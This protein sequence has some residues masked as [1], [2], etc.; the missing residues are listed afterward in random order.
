VREGEREREND[1]ERQGGALERELEIQGMRGREGE[2]AAHE[3]GV[4]DAG[5]RDAGRRSVG[6]AALAVA[7][8]P[9]PVRAM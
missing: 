9:H 1:N 4:E 8:Q 6:D 3:R 7:P 2:S 5:A